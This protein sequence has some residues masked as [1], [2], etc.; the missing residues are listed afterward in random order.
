MGG[1]TTTVPDRG[2]TIGEAAARLGLTTHTLR[3]YESED[4]LVGTPGRTSAGR[5]RYD[6]A[7]LRWIQMVQRLRATGM[8]VRSVR[9]YAELCRAGAG[10]EEQRLALL[11][12]HRQEVLAHLEEVTEHLTAITA[13]IEGYQAARA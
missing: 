7:D 2:L 4:L 6:E 11:H 1:V 12:A 5:R 9:A 13:K 3:Y 8:P 10:N